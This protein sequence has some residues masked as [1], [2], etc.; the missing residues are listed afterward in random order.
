MTTPQEF[1][2]YQLVLKLES[3]VERLKKV[4]HRL[5]W[6]WELRIWDPK[7]EGDEMILGSDTQPYMEQQSIEIVDL[8]PIVAVSKAPRSH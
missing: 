5:G 4:L 1:A 8:G 7:K 2:R 6:K 3:T